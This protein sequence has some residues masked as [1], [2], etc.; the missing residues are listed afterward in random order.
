[1]IIANYSRQKAVRGADGKAAWFTI[2]LGKE[3]RGEA[4]INPDIVVNAN[5][6]NPEF[7]VRNV[8][9]ALSMYL[10][11]SNVPWD[12]ELKMIIEAAMDSVWNSRG[13]MDGM[14]YRQTLSS[15]MGE[16]AKARS[17]WEKSGGASVHRILISERSGIWCE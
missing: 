11:Q 17:A 1:M 4:F 14:D 5:V 13:G 2:S 7:I 9:G 3:G 10:R 12:E 8:L 6:N 15:L 16:V